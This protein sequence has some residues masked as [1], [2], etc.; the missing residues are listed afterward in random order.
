M[1]TLKHI[2]NR[3]L[4]RQGRHVR[5]SVKYTETGVDG[6]NMVSDYKFDTLICL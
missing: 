6:L 5:N 3:V 2:H 1:R 4:H